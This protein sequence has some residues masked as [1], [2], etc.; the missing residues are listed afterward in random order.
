VLFRLRGKQNNIINRESFGGS[1]IRRV[2][3]HYQGQAQNFCKMATKEF[4]GFPREGFTPETRELSNGTIVAHAAQTPFWLTQSGLVFALTKDGV[5]KR[6]TVSGLKGHPAYGRRQA[7]GCHSG[8]RYPHL[9]HARKNYAAHKLMAL[10]WLGP[11]PAGWEVDHINGNILDWTLQNIQ[12]V[13]VAENRK[14]AVI[15]RARRMVARQDG[16]PD[17]LPENM[18]PEELLALFNKY[19]VAGDCYEGE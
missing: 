15:L 19:N 14:R 10:A 13:S 7:S 11:I 18:P 4:Y 9:G 8:E 5:W 2:R 12:I 17:L 3:T 16:R 6:R 1:D